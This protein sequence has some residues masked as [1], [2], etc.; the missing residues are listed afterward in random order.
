MTSSGC[1]P[2][3]PTGHAD[4]PHP[5]VPDSFARGVRKELRDVTSQ[6][7]QSKGL[8]VRVEG[9]PGQRPV[10]SL[11]PLLGLLAQPVSQTS[12]FRGQP[13]P[14]VRLRRFRSLRPLSRVGMHRIQA[15]HSSSDTDANPAGPLRST[16]VTPLP[17]YY[18]PRRPPA[19]ADHAV[20]L[21]RAALGLP[22][23]PPGLPGSSIDL[24]APAVSNHPGG[25]RPPRLP[26]PS[27]PRLGFTLSGRL[28]TPQKRNEAESSSLALRLTPSPPE[29]SPAG[30][31]RPPLGWLRVKR[32]TH[33]VISF[34]I[35][36]PIR[37]ILAHQRSQRP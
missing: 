30:S 1:L 9:P 28:A 21:S 33:T 29:A 11:A 20:M 2:P 6:H 22:P 35:T 4:F 24:S 36:R 3:H 13:D 17:R 31:L 7:H 12:K 5:A 37:L 10:P 15:A 25:A 14:V 26:V 27:R 18:E 34:Q 23:T 19:G 8:A 16:G 32:A